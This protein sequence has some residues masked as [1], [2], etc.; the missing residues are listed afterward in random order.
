MEHSFSKNDCAQFVNNGP[1]LPVRLLQAHEDGRVVFFCGAGISRSVFPDFAGLVNELYAKFRMTPNLSQKKAIKA[2]R[3]DIAAGL[4]EAKIVGGRA[5]V[6]RVLTSI[7]TDQTKPN[8]DTTHRYLLELSKNRDDNGTRLVTT[9]FDQLFEKVITDK[10]LQVKHF[11]APCLPIPKKQWNELVYLHGLLPES[12]TTSELNC[13]VISSGDFGRAYL[14]ERRG[15]RFVSE[16]FRNY[17]V[18]FVGYSLNDPVLRYMT[19]AIAADR[20]Q[21]ESPP[22]IFAFGSYSK[23]KKEE[24]FEEWECKNVTPILY[25]KH[26]HH[27]YLRKTLQAW[28]ETY[29]HGVVGKEDI[30]TEYAKKH[31]SESTKEDDF[32]S[33]VI[34]ALSDPSGLPAK[35]F[36]ELDLAPSLDWLK[37]LSEERYNH[38]DLDRFGILTKADFDGGNMFS[39][40]HRTSSSGLV[41]Y[42]LPVSTGAQNSKWDKVMTQLAS[43]LARHLSGSTLLPW[44]AKHSCSL[45][46]DLVD[47]I[48]L[49]LNKLNRLDDNTVMPERIR[50]NSHNTIPVHWRLLLTGCVSSSSRVRYT[51]L[52]LWKDR[53]KR[54]GLTTT[55]RQELRELLTPRISPHKPIKWS[56]KDDDSEPKHTHNLAGWEI[57]LFANNVLYELE[58]LAKDK[59]WFDASPELLTEFSS[60]LRDALDLMRELDGANDQSDPSCVLRPSISEHAQNR[61][62]YDWTA[63][64]TLTRDAW[65]ITAKESPERARNVAEGWSQEPYPLFRR[66]AFFAAAQ[67]ETIPNRQGLDWLLADE[68]WWLWSAHTRRETMQL[69]VALAPQLTKDEIAELE[70]AILNEPPHTMSESHI[71]QEQ[72]SDNGDWD[73]WLR[74]AK[75]VQAGATLSEDGR[76]KLAELSDKHPDWKPAKD[77]SDKIPVLTSVGGMEFVATP[78]PLH[79]LIKWLKRHS[80][81]YWREIGWQEDDWQQRCCDNFATAACALCALAKKGH[82]P[83]GRWSLALQVWSEE[84]MSECSWRYMAPV[85][86]NAA[87]EQLQPFALELSRWLGTV[88][89]TFVGQEEIFLKLCERVLKL[90]HKDETDSNNDFIM[91]AFNHPVGCA[92]KALLNWWRRGAPKDGQGLPDELK[93]TFTLLCDRSSDE[94]RYGRFFLAVNL[95]SLFRVDQDWTTKHLLPLFNWQTSETE[96]RTVWQGFLWFPR[97]YAPLMEVLK[98]DFL[99]TASHYKALANYGGRHAI[100]GKQYASLLTYAALNRGDVFEATELADATRKLSPDGLGYAAQE[101][102][103]TIEG[104]DERR[105]NCWKNRGAP[106]MHE[107]WPNTWD[108]VYP[109]VAAD[110]GCVCIATQEAFPEAF[111]LLKPWLKLSTDPSKRH[112]HYRHTL[113]QQLHETKICS[114]FPEPA[115]NFLDLV[116]PRQRCRIPEELGACLKAIR[117][118]KT[119]DP[120]LETDARYQRLMVCVRQQEVD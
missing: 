69:L 46:H 77:E 79:E 76:K 13:L 45:H 54:D 104:A 100:Y 113:L 42:M 103:R 88:A 5:K 65:L 22:E 98:T 108:R 51:A 63:L 111:K 86:V 9:N 41:S 106:Y 90:K 89:K 87:D 39:L 37:T 33:R 28:S 36:A 48:E 30:V 3:Y 80:R 20:Q 78:R 4:L 60:L 102:I 57:V 27:Y 75:I 61:K 11:Q 117:S 116:I 14:T 19:D 84:K 115:L 83:D 29:R 64:I 8:K 31:P 44:M 58:E 91:R 38:T 35:L 15:A 107:I 68:H 81:S 32:V 74:L 34:W 56:A 119:A 26:Y 97:F 71:D 16:L 18:C 67:G 70:K 50:S 112:D 62:R 59:R 92:T 101:L 7:L 49:R 40:P 10:E 85:L 52:S 93:S 25:R 6:R 12:P 21:G 73:I 24:Q 96:A 1:H 72:Q 82:W 43:W 94:F 99:D 17:V 110:L 120:E 109:A 53:F 66:L 114:K 95:I 105:D 2:G 47:L 23:G 118:A 55:L